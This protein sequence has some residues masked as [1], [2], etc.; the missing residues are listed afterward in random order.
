[1]NSACHAD[2]GN[3]ENITASHEVNKTKKWSAKVKRIITKLFVKVQLDMKLNLFQ[4][5]AIF[6][7]NFL[8]FLKEKGGFMQKFGYPKEI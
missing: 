5:N 2:S 3:L 6:I 4:E 7:S 1:M 8:G